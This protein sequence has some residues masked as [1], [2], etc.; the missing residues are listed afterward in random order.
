MVSQ[1]I[2]HSSP[3]VP[4]FLRKH[5]SLWTPWC[6]GSSDEAGGETLTEAG[7][8]QLASWPLLGGFARQLC[9]GEAACPL[10]QPGCVGDAEIQEHLQGQM[11]RAP[12]RA[13][14]PAGLPFS[15]K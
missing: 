6:P 5:C 11:L 7:A 4:S 3:E 14:P 1:R 2:P 9:S 10:S 8:V 12:L 13:S 15:A